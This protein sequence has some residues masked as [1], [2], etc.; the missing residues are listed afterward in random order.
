M[1]C[2][3]IMKNKRFLALALLVLM[4][5]VAL[6][7]CGNKPESNV[8]SYVKSIGEAKNLEYTIK[9]YRKKSYV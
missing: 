3:I 4:L 5:C 8:K 7:S 6:A 2:E 1:E 9:I